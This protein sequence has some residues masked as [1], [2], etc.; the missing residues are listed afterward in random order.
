MS[1]P[2]EALTATRGL[3]APGGALLIA[4]EKVA[5]SFTAPG[6]EVER[7]MYGYSVL[8]C[9][10]NSLA[11]AGFRRDRDRAP[12]GPDARARGPGR[13]LERH[14]PA[15]RARHVPLLP[16]RPVGPTR[17]G[18]RG[19]AHHVRDAALQPGIRRSMLPRRLVAGREQPE[20]ERPRVP[21]SRGQSRA[22]AGAAVGGGDR[23]GIG[24]G[25]GG[26]R[27]RPP[28]SL[29]IKP[30]LRRT[31]GFLSNFAIAFSFISVSTGSS[32]QLRD[33]HRAGRAGVLLVVAD[34]HHRPAHRRPRLRRAGEPLPGRGLDLPVVEA[35]LEPDARLVHRL[36]L[37]LGPRRHGNRC[38]GDRR[39]SSSTASTARSENFLDSPDPTGL[40][41]ACSRSSPS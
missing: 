38:R 20:S 31:L 32:R 15:R 33:R 2:V 13:L 12:T 16:P 8:F 24:P 4:D 10:P 14:D 39:R 7:I 11:E 18:R 36:V 19:P 17:T 21:S 22:R 5:E 27:R 41:D 23:G 28:A 37:L 9:L 26:A 30:E 34:R 6:D 25:P 40:D 3:L 29:G 35:P 1:H